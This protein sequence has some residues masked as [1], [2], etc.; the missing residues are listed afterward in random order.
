[1]TDEAQILIGSVV[2]G[3]NHKFHASMVIY[4]ITMISRQFLSTCLTCTNHI[5]HNMK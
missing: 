2:A 4:H 1:M 3:V 5:K